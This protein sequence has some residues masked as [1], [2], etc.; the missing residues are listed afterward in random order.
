MC[1]SKT[2][3]LV[4]DGQESFQHRANWSNDD[5]PVCLEGSRIS[6]MKQKFLTFLRQT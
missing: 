2:A 1:V 4:I 3:L 5:L 6:S